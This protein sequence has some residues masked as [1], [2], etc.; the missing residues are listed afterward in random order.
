MLTLSLALWAVFGLA[1]AG[2]S[3]SYVMVAGA[4]MEPGLKTGD[5]VIARQ[6]DS[7]RVGEVV[8]YQHPRLGPII[9][10]IIDLQ[11]GAFVLQ[12][13]SN[14][15]IDSYRPAKAE[16]L[17]KQW[18]TVPGAATALQMLR[19]PGWLAGFS[20]LIAMVFLGVLRFPRAR[21]RPEQG[22]PPERRPGTP[23]P[24]GADSYVLLFAV[25]G[26]AGLLLA[27]VAFRQPS[28]S[29]V[30]MV[31]PFEQAGT[32]SYSAEGP[33]SVY[34]Q[35]R[36]TTGDPIFRA[37]LDRFQIRFDYAFIADAPAQIRGTYALAAELRD[38][39]GWS[40]RVILKPKT[41]FAGTTL[42]IDGEVRLDSGQA[43]IDS[44][45][46]KSG[47]QRAAFTLTV[48]P[49]IEVQGT[50][51][52]RE[53]K[54]AFAP[55]PD[56]WLDDL[57]VS[58]PPAAPTNGEDD[59]LH[60]G[61][62]GGVVYLTEQPYTIRILGI[63]PTVLMARWSAVILMVIG[64]AGLVYLAWRVERARRA[65]EAQWIR[66]RYPDLIL[67]AEIP[68]DSTGL[69]AIPVASFDDPVRAAKNS[70]S[71]VTHWTGEGQDNYAVRQAERLYVYQV[72]SS[73]PAVELR[74]SGT[75]QSGGEEAG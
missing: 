74:D 51:E 15:W 1:A 60:P 30:E 44:M 3:S 73:P 14:P 62:S 24:S 68:P 69:E 66:A 36:V 46:T 42:A 38:A 49:E 41:A 32:F 59:P 25:L 34:D 52:G 56:F 64:L 54:A 5:L 65:G 45:R 67:T 27:I 33:R 6:S 43:M 12:G 29:T 47:L 9:H 20:V 31:L 13:D 75:S 61:S 50:L 21:S 57:Q 4:S 63:E 22:A 37:L 2:G 40:R 16:I 8:A 58:L 19:H 55:E 26:L 28:S 35:G 53:L 7:Y 18:L 39:N 72:A 71:L 70:N 48:L 23:L 11:G 10:R 17:G